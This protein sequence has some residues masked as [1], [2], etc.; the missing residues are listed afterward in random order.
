MRI[1]F[2][3]RPE[4]NEFAWA[5]EHGFPCVEFNRA[6][7]HVASQREVAPDVRAWSKQYGVDV[8]SFGYFGAEYFS[9]DE[10]VRKLALDDAA[11]A[12]ETCAELGAP[13]FVLGTG[14]RPTRPMPKLGFTKPQ[15]I[16]IDEACRMAIETLGPVVEK[17]ESLGLKVAFYNCDWANFCYNESAWGAM[18]ATFP[19]AGIKFDPSHPFYRGEDYLA[20]MRDWGHRFWHTHAKGGMKTL[21]GERIE[22][23]PAGMDQVDWPSFMA[24]LHRAAYEGDLNIEPHSTTWN[25]REGMRRRGILFTQKYLAPFLAEAARP[26]GTGA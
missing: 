21:G 7:G 14:S 13:V 8:S 4:E 15:P 12:V 24:L 19:K 17:A 20:Q 16:P 1:G 26:S 11:N 2:I 5:A 3:A 22:D 6:P 18:L 25:R 23:P 9:G 10:A